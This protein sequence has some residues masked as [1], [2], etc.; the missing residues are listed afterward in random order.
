MPR[1][2]MES[3]V[4]SYVSAEM[5]VGEAE[6]RT[7]ISTMSDDEMTDMIRKSLIEQLSAKILSG[8]RGAARRI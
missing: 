6:V 8:C 7:Y 4:I 5:K 1:E 2:D 3:A